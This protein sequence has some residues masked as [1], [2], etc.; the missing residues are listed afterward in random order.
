MRGAEDRFKNLAKLNKAERSQAAWLWDHHVELEAWHRALPAPQASR[1]NHPSTIWRKNPLGE[2]REKKIR[3]TRAKAADV[4]DDAAERVRAP[5][6]ASRSRPR[7][8]PASICRPRR[9][10]R[11]RREPWSTI[12]APD[13]RPSCLIGLRHWS[14]AKSPSRR[15]W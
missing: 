5:P 14:S 10:S 2:Y 7:L 3:T 13:G 15:S 9:W 11:P 6:S 12:T 4:L 8:T 1:Y